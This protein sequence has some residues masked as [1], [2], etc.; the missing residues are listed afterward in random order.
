MIEDVPAKPMATGPAMKAGPAGAP[1]ALQ[2]GEGREAGPCGPA[3]ALPERV[4]DRARIPG[5]RPATLLISRRETTLTVA[6]APVIDDTAPN[7][8]HDVTDAAG[9]KSLPAKARTC[10]RARL[11]TAAAATLRPRAALRASHTPALTTSNSPLGR[12]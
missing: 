2:Q 12:S 8:R 11:S 9:F 3:L 5:V 7:H 4:D 6:G 1:R 10:E